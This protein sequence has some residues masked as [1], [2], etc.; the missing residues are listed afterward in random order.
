MNLPEDCE[1][2]Y[3]V[4]HEDHLHTLTQRDKPA[5]YVAAVHQEGDHVWEFDVEEHN[6][7]FE[8]HLQLQIFDDSW[9]AFEQIPEFFTALR[10]ACPCT[11]IELRKVLDGLGARD[12]TPRTR[13]GEQK[14]AGTS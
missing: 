14:A 3:I 9:D 11:L 13:P 12:A 7:P 4:C 2:T 10:T 8:Q 6:S 5:I 1:L